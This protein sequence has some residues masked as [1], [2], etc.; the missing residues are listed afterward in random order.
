M[1]SAAVMVKSGA[2]GVTPMPTWTSS[3]L[4]RVSS[5]PRPICSVAATASEPGTFVPCNSVRPLRLNSKAPRGDVR[6]LAARFH[7]R[8]GAAVCTPKKEAQLALRLR[9]PAGEEDE[10][11]TG[12][13]P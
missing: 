8:F 7:A 1:G 12:P 10:D 6:G 11:S 5:M 3:R 2:S 9:G 4:L 13:I